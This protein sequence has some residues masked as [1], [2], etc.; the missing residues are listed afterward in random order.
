MPKK[1]KDGRYRAKVTIPGAGPVYVSGRTTKELEQAK[2][3]ARENLLGVRAKADITF[4]QLVITWWN[5][6]KLPRVKTASTRN[7]YRTAINRYVLP[8]FREKQLLRAVRRKDLQDCLDMC[9]G[10]STGTIEYVTA[11][12]RGAV[13]YGLS[14]G[15]ISSDIAASLLLPEGKQPT[16]KTSFNPE[17]SNRV[18]HVAGESQDG[19]I[20][21]L[22]YYL[23]LRRGEMLG[24]QWGDVDFNRRTVRICRSISFSESSG[25]SEIHEPKTERGKRSV[26]LP[27]ALYDVLMTVRGQPEHYIVS[28]D[29]GKSHLPKN[30]FYRKWAELMISCGFTAPSAQYQRREEAALKQGKEPPPPGSV[31]DYTLLVTPHAFRHNYVTACV[32]AGIPPEVT[33]RIV[34]HANYQT[35]V[36]IYTH[37]QE[38]QIQDSA[39]D[40]AS[41]LEPGNLPNPNPFD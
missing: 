22:L 2:K 3:A 6:F 4:R 27:Q 33:M 25:E 24:L 39:A 20:L 26:P 16:Q 8:F 19:L 15:M 1:Q 30:I 41:M 14:E 21:Y 11:V 28:S 40:L 18:L 35:T 17:Q 32:L 29:G 37:I 23:G 38:Q 36:N 9:S 31:R 34:G 7:S 10:R 5:D 12:L 13:R